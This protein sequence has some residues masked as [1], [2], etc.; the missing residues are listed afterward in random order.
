METD[1]ANANG[2]DDDTPPEW[3]SQ[4]VQ[5]LCLGP[6]Q[7]LIFSRARRTRTQLLCVWL[8]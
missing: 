1:D 6:A 5:M 2:E 4:L 8:R 3:H 7:Q